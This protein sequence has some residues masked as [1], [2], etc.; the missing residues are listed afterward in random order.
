MMT[1]QKLVNNDNRLRSR[2]YFS[3][4]VCNSRN[5][6]MHRYAKGPVASTPSKHATSEPLVLSSIGTDSDRY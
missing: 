4:I 1:Q 6:T 2:I 3:C 5:A